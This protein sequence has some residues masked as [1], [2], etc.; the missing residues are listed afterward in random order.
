MLG[1]GREAVVRAILLV[2][3]LIVVSDVRGQAADEPRF[4]RTWHSACTFEG[5]EES[6][7][8]IRTYVGRYEGAFEVSDFHITGSE[9]H[10]WLAG[11]IAALFVGAPES[12]V[13]DI[14]VE[15]VLSPSRRTGYG[16]RGY[17]ERELAVTRV[18]VVTR[19]DGD[20]IENAQR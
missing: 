14:T 8:V 5:I 12:V 10:V 17:Y 9:C 13:A 11:E 16:H 7:G 4:Q 3:L 2:A 19:I 1:G 18:L 6:E 20:A 15:G